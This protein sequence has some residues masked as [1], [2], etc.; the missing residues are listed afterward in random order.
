METASSSALIHVN[1]LKFSYGDRPILKGVD[2]EIPR[3]KLVGILGTSGSGKTTLLKLLSGQL[4]PSAGYVKFEG[5]IVHELDDE[6]LY[7]LRRKMGMQF[8][9][10]GLFSDLSVFDN[11]A[12]P[13]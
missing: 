4:K 2:L 10:S 12:F 1:G 3:G 7:A 5:S 8:Q 11:I 9:V 13:M 6:K